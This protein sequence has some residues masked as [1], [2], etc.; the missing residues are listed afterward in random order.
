M[1]D[2]EKS[3]G[4]HRRIK[5]VGRSNKGDQFGTFDFRWRHN[6]Y[7]FERKVV[8]SVD[9]GD[10]WQRLNIVVHEAKGMNYHARA[11]IHAEVQ[12]L[13]PLFFEADEIPLQ[14]HFPDIRSREGITL[15]H[16]KKQV[17]LNKTLANLNKTI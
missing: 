3:I 6:A 14:L 17:Q 7:S 1:K 5:G 2:L 10:S 12:R 4:M 13:L 16:S 15:W 8:C 9:V 11:P